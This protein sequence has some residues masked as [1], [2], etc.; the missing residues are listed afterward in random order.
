MPAQDSLAPGV[1]LRH[2]PACIVGLTLGLAGASQVL[3]GFNQWPP[4]TWQL[5]WLS[6]TLA[7]AGVGG[8]WASLSQA[9]PVSLK[10]DY[11]MVSICIQPGYG[12]TQDQR[13]WCSLSR[14][15][16]NNL[17]RRIA[18]CEPVTTSGCN[19]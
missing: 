12:V 19:W 8:W 3:A 18:E 17:T 7:T 16:T 10:K 13:A 4:T 15:R 9:S 2:P 6:V 14:R 11:E 5:V 1:P